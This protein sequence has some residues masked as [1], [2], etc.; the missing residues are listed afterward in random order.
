MYI[1]RLGHTK[2]SFSFPSSSPSHSPSP[3]PPCP[4][5][6]I[7][8][9]GSQ[10]SCHEDTWAACGEA[11]VGRNGNLPPRTS[12]YLPDVCKTTWKWILWP[13]SGLQMM[14]VLANILTETSQ[15]TLSQNCLVK[16][17]LNF[18]PIETVK[19]I[20]CCRPLNLGA[21]CLTAVGN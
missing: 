3:S 8:F 18:W 4:S 2:D 16:L 20:N 14:P 1:L 19:I 17:F 6:F 21:V 13:L 7:C 5:I 11:Q 10:P 12:T 15:K 9:G